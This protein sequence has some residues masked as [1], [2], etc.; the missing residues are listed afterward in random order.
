MRQALGTRTKREPENRL[1]RSPFLRDRLHSSNY[2]LVK[3]AIEFQNL[4]HGENRTCM[5]SEQLQ[6]EL[7][8]TDL[9]IQRLFERGLACLR[10]EKPCMNERVT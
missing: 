2:I 9:D 10:P 7:G 6:A 4:G 1:L 8:L 3:I 5:D